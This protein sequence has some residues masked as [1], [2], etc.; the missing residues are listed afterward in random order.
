MDIVSC[1][2]AWV[3]IVVRVLM[4]PSVLISIVRMRA[5]APAT[6][7]IACKCC[8]W[9]PRFSPLACCMSVFECPSVH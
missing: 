4:L 5:C 1:V 2:A 8:G 6:S 3:L 9:T 7:S